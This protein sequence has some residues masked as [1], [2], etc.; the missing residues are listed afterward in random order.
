MLHLSTCPISEIGKKRLQYID[1][2]E[3]EAIRRESETRKKTKQIKINF[4]ADS[5]K[6][7]DKIKVKGIRKGEHQKE[8]TKNIVESDEDLHYQRVVL[9]C[10]YRTLQRQ[11]TE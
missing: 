3:K 5:T 7:R 8:K 4:S 6:S 1:T 9:S 11:P 2:T 10:L